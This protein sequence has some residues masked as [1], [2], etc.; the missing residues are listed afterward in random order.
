M[1]SGY[2][3]P[4]MVN[5]LPEL[6]LQTIPTLSNGVPSWDFQH[7]ESRKFVVVNLGTNDFAWGDPGNANYTGA[8]ASLIS[9]VRTYYGADTYIFRMR[10]LHGDRW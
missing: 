1:Y 6:W 7:V 3:G 4:P 9:Q 5:T 2:T 8:Y 10:Q